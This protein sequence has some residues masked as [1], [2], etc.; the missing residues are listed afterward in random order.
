[1]A[2]SSLDASLEIDFVETAKGSVYKYLPD[3]RTQRFKKAEN[4]MKEPQDAL[5]FVPPYDWVWKS[6]PKELIANNAFGE[7]ELIYDEILLSYVQGEGKKNYIVDR[8]GRKLETNKQIAQTNGDVYLTFGDAKKVDF[9]IPVSKAPK[10]GWCTY[11]TRKYMN[12]AQTMRERH[13]GNKVVKIAYRDGR[14]VS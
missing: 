14:I 9:Y 13:L 5:V 2:M 11:D 4:K 12:G 10:L 3:G 7:N 8:N 6:A 1:M